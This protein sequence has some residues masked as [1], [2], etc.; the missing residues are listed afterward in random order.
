MAQGF[1]VE[2]PPARVRSQ[3]HVYRAGAREPHPGN[4]PLIT[5]VGEHHL[6]TGAGQREQRG[7]HG[8]EPAAADHHLRIRVVAVAGP[9][10]DLIRHR[11]P[12]AL[13]ASERQVRRRP[14]QIRERVEGC[15]ERGRGRGEVGVKVFHPQHLRAQGVGAFGNGDDVQRGDVGEA[16]GA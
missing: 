5:G 8:G 2:P 9:G 11:F 16:A 13:L 14:A 4:E 3:W 1:H 10:M 15:G 7:E 12:E 6:V